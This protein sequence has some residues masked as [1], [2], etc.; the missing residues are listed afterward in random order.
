MFGGCFCCWGYHIVLFWGGLSRGVFCIAWLCGMVLFGWQCSR[1]NS[2]FGCW[3]VFLK[4]LVFVG[5][6][7]ARGFV[8]IGFLG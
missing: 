7:G 4:P 3:F 2:V 1:F 6:L 8:W 5:F